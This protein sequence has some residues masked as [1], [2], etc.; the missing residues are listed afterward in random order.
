MFEYFTTRKHALS[1][2]T[3]SRV[4]PL[5]RACWVALTSARSLECGVWRPL[6]RRTVRLPHT[7]HGSRSPVI[8]VA[9]AQ[10]ARGARDGGAEQRPLA[11]CRCSVCQ[12]E[13]RAL[14]LHARLLPCPV[15][16]RALARPPH[17]ARSAR[18]LAAAAARPAPPRLPPLL[19][20]TP[21][22]RRSGTDGAAT[23]LSGRCS[24]P[25]S[26]APR[27][28]CAAAAA[29]PSPSVSRRMVCG[30]RTGHAQRTRQLVLSSTAASPPPYQPRRAAAAAAAPAAAPVVPSRTYFKTK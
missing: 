3:V 29:P 20:R 17:R 27:A 7:R 15:T 18:L 10:R 1:R 4:S 12:P 21:R 2:R 11:R 16:R 23:A 19:T 14:P 30:A 24:A 9:A 22:R 8:T 5:S 26:R 6:S 28:R 13:T 25:P